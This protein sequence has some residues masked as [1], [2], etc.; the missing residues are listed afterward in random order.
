MGDCRPTSCGQ[1]TAFG[2]PLQLKKTIRNREISK[3]T[4]P[5]M[6]ESRPECLARCFFWETQIFCGFRRIKQ[7]AHVITGVSE[8]DQITISELNILI[9]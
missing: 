5:P 1:A 3:R 6:N 8:P 9:N 2:A 4:S 7:E